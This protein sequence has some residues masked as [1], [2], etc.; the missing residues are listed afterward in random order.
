MKNVLRLIR[1]VKNSE[2]L[3]EKNKILLLCE[4]NSRFGSLGNDLYKWCEVSLIKNDN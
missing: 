2:S 4:N 3:D 1:A